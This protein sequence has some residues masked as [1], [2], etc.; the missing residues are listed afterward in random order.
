MSESEIET[1]PFLTPDLP[2][3]GGQLKQTPEDFVVEE[4]PVYE[5]T[6]AGEHLFLWIEKRDVSA[7][8]LVKILS[9]ELQL[10]PRDIGVAGL[11]DRF[12][13]TRQYVSVP[14]T[15]EPLVETF[16]FTGIQILKATRHENKLKTGH[17]KGNRFSLVVRNTEDDALVKAQAIAKSITQNGF[18]NYY[19]A[20]RMGRDNET[21]E[22]GLKLLRGE[23]VPGKYLRNKALKRLALSAVQSALFNRV[24][25]NR[26][27]AG[28]LF[29]VQAGDVMQVSA[30]GGL[31]VV[32]YVAAE[33]L[34]FDQGETMITGPLFGPKMKQPAQETSAQEQQALSDF[35]LEPEQFTR[36]KKLTAGTRRPLL[37]RPAALQLESAENGVCFEF[38]LPSGVYATMLL[39]E[40]MKTE[41]AGDMT[42][43]S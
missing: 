21:F 20:Q 26:L 43:T 27:Q 28:Q 35:G 32:E 23:R 30:S 13:V 39:R 33:Q 40:F 7:P 41:A 8:Y 22:M 10:N 36:Y 5:P 14:A 6:G 12:A 38:T 29:T 11:K 24:L 18:P 19:G 37:I 3:I 2:G 15:C 1:L 34:R 4:I 17:L 16:E 25:A 9:R 31:F 42:E